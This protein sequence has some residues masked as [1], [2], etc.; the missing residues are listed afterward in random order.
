MSES[1][2]LSLSIHLSIYPSIH[3]MRERVGAPRHRSLVAESVNRSVGLSSTDLAS[4]HAWSSGQMVVVIML[5]R[6][7]ATLGASNCSSAFWGMP[8]SVPVV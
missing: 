3:H 5:I 1:A 6:S 4:S 2:R 8:G 7:S